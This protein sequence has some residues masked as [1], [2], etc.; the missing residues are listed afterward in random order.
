VVREAILSSE[1]MSLSRRGLHNQALADGCQPQVSG[2]IPVSMG[3]KPSRKT[4]HGSMMG[5]ARSLRV[6]PYT[7]AHGADQHLA[8]GLFVYMV[9]AG[10]Q[11]E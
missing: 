11:V 4:D 10:I 2:L 7:L 3:I 8:A 1:K 6:D 5:L 9:D